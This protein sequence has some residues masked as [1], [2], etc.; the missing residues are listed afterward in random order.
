MWINIEKIIQ[1]AF[2]APKEIGI[3]EYFIMSLILLL[4][5]VIRMK[6]SDWNEVLKIPR[7]VKNFFKS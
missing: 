2:S 1:V 6:P 3:R 5:I 7:R 4:C